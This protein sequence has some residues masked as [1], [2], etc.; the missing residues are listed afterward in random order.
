MSALIDRICTWI[1]ARAGLSASDLAS[2]VSEVLGALQR[3]EKM[4][5]DLGKYALSLDLRLKTIEKV[6]P[7]FALRAEVETIRRDVVAY[8]TDLHAE[9]VA[10]LDE[11]KVN[12]LNVI[13]GLGKVVRDDIKEHGA[14]LSRAIADL[15]ARLVVLE[16]AGKPELPKISPY[17]ARAR[18]LAKRYVLEAEQQCDP[19]TSGE[20]KRHRV[21]A[22]LKKVVPEIKEK[23]LALGIELA[24]RDVLS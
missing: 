22:E 2:Y 15:D 16:S 3:L 19:S 20:F 7:D 24:V 1:A 11:A 21:L 23:D 17:V 12:L 10:Q 18:H 9:A 14:L 8:S 13:E 6:V 5:G 4:Q